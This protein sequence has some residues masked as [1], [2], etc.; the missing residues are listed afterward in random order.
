M[1]SFLSSQSISAYDWRVFLYAPVAKISIL[2]SLLSCSHGYPG[3]LVRLKPLRWNTLHLKVLRQLG[4]CDWSFPTAAPYVFASCSQLFSDR[5]AVRLITS[6]IVKL[7]PDILTK[8]LIVLCAPFRFPMIF[9][10]S[11]VTST[12]QHV[13]NRMQNLEKKVQPLS[14]FLTRN[15]WH[16]S[17]YSSG[18]K[19]SWRVGISVW[20]SQHELSWLLLL[21]THILS[22][23][24]LF[25]W[26]FYPGENL[27]PAL[28]LISSPFPPLH[29]LWNMDIWASASD[30]G[31]IVPIRPTLPQI[32]TINY[33]IKK[34]KNQSPEGN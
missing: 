30:N 12:T 34:Y 29:A 26:A 9:P 4:W 15:S 19:C 2:I 5:Q 18:W 21:W 28:C 25:A 14:P 33:R 13:L 23:R 7:N 1:P 22:S 24:I 31:S 8:A 6:H 16:F 32:T 10:R 11:E 17:P 3:P 20:N 27:D